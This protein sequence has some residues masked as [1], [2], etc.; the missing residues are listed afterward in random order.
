MKITRKNLFAIKE[1]FDRLSTEK[2]NVLFHYNVAKN[3]RIIEA[4]L[5][6]LKEAKQLD[7]NVISKLKSY[8]SK[9][10]ELCKEYCLKNEDDEPII[11]DNRFE[12][13]EE[14]KEA[15][16]NKLKELSESEDFKPALIARE[17]LEEQYEELLNEEVEL[18]LIKFDLNKLPTELLG[19]DID[20][21]FDLIEE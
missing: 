17:Q 13:N 7:E 9:R 11:L 5:D 15:F 16:N 6:S 10:V 8:E 1:V 19:S 2:T 4:E 20:I 3:K 21:L 18:P 14:G 12:F